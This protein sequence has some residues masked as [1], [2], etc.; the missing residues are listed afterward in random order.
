MKLN[1]LRPEPGSRH[2]PKRVGRGPGS[3]HGKTSC[4]GHNGQNAR[5]GGGVKPGF[6]GGQLP[7]YRRVPKRG[8]THAGKNYAI[9]NVGDLNKFTEIVTSKELFEAGMIKNL[10]E[11]TKILGEG[12]L[13]K[14]LTIKADAFSESAKVKIEKAGGK[15]VQLPGGQ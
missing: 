3:G 5:S 7:L 15:A 12:T 11:K 13:S 1:E 2:A 10:K 14:V 6:E 4:R 9:I 8:F